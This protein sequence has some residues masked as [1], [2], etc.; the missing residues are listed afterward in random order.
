MQQRS[1]SEYR[2]ICDNVGHFVGGFC[3]IEKHVLLTARIEEYAADALIE[4]AKALRRTIVNMTLDPERVRSDI[5]AFRDSCCGISK[6]LHELPLE[7]EER[8]RLVKKVKRTVAGIGGVAIVGI[9]VSSIV[10]TVGL[11]APGAAVS[12][13][14]GSGLIGAALVV[15]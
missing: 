10:V 5:V 7:E 14:I 11:S 1:P 2:E 13:A 6:R 3:V 9:N 15:D 8:R 12:G 4:Q